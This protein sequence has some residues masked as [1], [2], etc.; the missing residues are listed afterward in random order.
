M[1]IV[2]QC[3][4]LLGWGFAWQNERHHR[5]YDDIKLRNTNQKIDLKISS[6]GVAVLG[7]K[8]SWIKTVSLYQVRAFNTKIEW[9]T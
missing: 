4:K 6:N 7:K 9:S 3:T 1:I 2:T 8:S 5:L